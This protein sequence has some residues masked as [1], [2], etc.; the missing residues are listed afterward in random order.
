M[1]VELKTITEHHIPCPDCE[2]TGFRVDHLFGLQAC[3]FGPWWCRSCG[4]GIEGTVTGT[5]VTVTEVKTDHRCYPAAV[6]LEI[7][8]QKESIFVVVEFRIMGHVVI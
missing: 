4:C 7:P 8:P 1:S 3:R 5:A 2:A 6:L